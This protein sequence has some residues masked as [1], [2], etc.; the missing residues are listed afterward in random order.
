MLSADDGGELLLEFDVRHPMEHGPLLYKEE[1]LCS[2]PVS[3][4]PLDAHVGRKPIYNELSLDLTPFLYTKPFAQSSSIEMFMHDI[5][6]C[7]VAYSMF[8]YSTY[9]VK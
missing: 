2:M 5:T 4:V 1:F 3:N 9:I 8:Q 6:L 7:V